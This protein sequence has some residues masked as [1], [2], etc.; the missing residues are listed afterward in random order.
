MFLDVDV[1]VDQGQY[2]DIYAAPAGVDNT[3]DIVSICLSFV[4]HF[5]Y[6]W[7]QST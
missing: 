3:A 6:R 4:C 2:D 7:H 1:D 5:P